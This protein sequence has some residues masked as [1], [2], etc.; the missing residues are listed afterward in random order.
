V[1][2]LALRGVLPA[3]RTLVR[4]ALGAAL[5]AGVVL[6]PVAQVYREVDDRNDLTR[7]D[8]RANSLLP[9]DLFTPQPDNWSWGTALDSIN[10]VGKAGEHHFFPGFLAMALGAIGLVVIWR[11]A[12]GRGSI[13]RTGVRIDEVLALLVAGVLA[14]VFALGRAPGGLP[15]PYRL[16]HDWVPGFDAVRVTSRFAVVGFLALALLAGLAFQHLADR[17]PRARRTMLAAGI[18]AIVLIEVGGPTARV[19]VPEGER[20]LVYEELATREDGVVLELPIRTDEEGNTWAF[21]EAPRMYHATTDWNSRINGYS[22]SAPAGFEELA[23]L[24]GSW[25]SEAAERRLD[26][27]AV[28]YIVLHGGTE[29]G[30]SALTPEQQGALVGRAEVLGFEASR[31]GEDWLIVRY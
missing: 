7:G 17:V 22:G 24:V 4:P 29:Q 5:V 19:D 28:R 30:T 27:L 31:H 12:R 1:G 10:S 2:V 11:V 14:F 21:V 13:L 16:L 20:L 9:T 3:A 8:E 18:A 6:G 15:G 23:A 25:P 26:E